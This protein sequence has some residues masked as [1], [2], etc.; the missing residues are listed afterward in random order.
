MDF[1]IEA[2]R[3]ICICPESL[4]RAWSISIRGVLAS[5]AV[6]L[7]AY[8]CEVQ[9]RISINGQTIRA[10]GRNRVDSVGDHLQGSGKEERQGKG[11]SLCE[12]GHSGLLAI[13]DE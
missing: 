9:R 3:I 10:H 6:S 7:W 8:V 4:Q 5:A 13:H 11:L 12:E 2:A 1:H